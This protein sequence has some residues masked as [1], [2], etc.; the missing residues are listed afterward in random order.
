MKNYINYIII[1]ISIITVA[2]IGSRAFLDRYKSS[3]IIYVTGLGSEDFVSDLIVWQG[4]F[5]RKS[6]L[7]KDAYKEID[8]DMNEIKSYLINKGISEEEIVFSSVNINREYDYYY[9]DN[10]RSRSVFSGYNLTQNVQIESKNVDMIESISREVTELINAGI[11]FYS[12]PPSY[13]YTKLAE[14]KLEMIAK[15]TDDARR[16]AEKIAENSGSEIGSLK[17][18]TMGVFQIIAQNSSEDYSWGGTYNTTSKRKTA[19]ITMR[20]QFKIK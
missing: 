4:S 14:L 3:E 10:G 17:S 20:L 11:E 16:R 19:T 2:L 9:D 1:G 6:T 15:A 12:Y 5:S 7:L 18:A 13:Y 8:S